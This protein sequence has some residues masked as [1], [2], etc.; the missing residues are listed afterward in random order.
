MYRTAAGSSAGL[1][2]C[3]GLAAP[4][5]V[6]QTLE[7]IGS[8]HFGDLTPWDAKNIENDAELCP[9]VVLLVQ[10]CTCSWLRLFYFL[11]ATF[12][13][14]HSTFGQYIQAEWKHQAVCKCFFH[15]FQAIQLQ[16]NVAMTKREEEKVTRKLSAH[17]SHKFI[18]FL[19]LFKLHE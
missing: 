4:T 10:R 18:F 9:T 15:A 1:W 16:K 12:P 19:Y 17:L 7:P 11:C 13:C 14:R 2:A 3:P 5:A 8:L 6:H